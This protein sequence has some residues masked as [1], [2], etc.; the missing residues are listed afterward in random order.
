MMWKSTSSNSWEYFIVWE[1]LGSNF[2]FYVCQ[3]YVSYL[4][5][6]IILLL[7]LNVIGD[8]LILKL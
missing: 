7:G 6:Y 5:K 8:N 1:D 3:L 2:K 4:N